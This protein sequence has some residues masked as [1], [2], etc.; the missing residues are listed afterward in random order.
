MKID[1]SALKGLFKRPL[2]LA[3]S[4]G[5]MA[6]LVVLI[7]ALTSK[8]GE[9]A[10]GWTR[11]QVKETDDSVTIESSG[12]IE[13]IRYGDLSFA[14]TGLISKLYVDEGDGVNKG[15]ELA[16]LDD[17]EQR[18]AYE[19]AKQRLEQYRLTGNARQTA[20]AELELEAKAN[21]LDKATIRA[22]FSGFVTSVE[23]EPGE[24][25][26]NGTVVLSL[27]DRSSLVATLQIDEVDIPQLKVGQKVL[28]SFD[29]L[30]G[31]SYAGTVTRIPPVGRVTSQGLAVFDVTAT[32]PNPPAELLP[33]FSFSARVV[34]S[35]A[36]PVLTL[37]LSA[38]VM[39]SGGFTRRGSAEASDQTAAQGAA[40]VTGAVGAVSPAAPSGKDSSGAQATSPASASAARGRTF[41]CYVPGDNGTPVLKDFV[42]FLRSDG[43]IQIVS[44][45]EAGAVVLVQV[46]EST[47]SSGAA[48][49]GIN[50][51]IPGMGGMPGGQP[52][53]GAVPGSGLRQ[54]GGSR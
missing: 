27:V 29:A 36:E 9:A 14:G 22:P 50:F 1:L 12:N 8:G 13:A 34:V 44:G 35:Q 28:F 40:P 54:S 53:A 20:L 31:S 21:N 15:Q 49:Q 33:G 41:Q 51:A 19:E 2:R 26:S 5:A 38:V 3:L 4:L 11:V 6:I 30:P 10:S 37:P 45:L 39:P 23:V 48:A 42:G 43:T 46:T 24:Y 52:P 47:A 17:V 32:I 16:A 18:Y 7:L 25:V